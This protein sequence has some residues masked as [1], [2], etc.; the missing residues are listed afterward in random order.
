MPYY[1]KKIVSGD[2]VEIEQ[3]FSSG[4]RIP[5][6]EKR[7]ITPLTQTEYNERQSEKEFIRLLNCNFDPAR[8]D[9]FATLTFSEAVD[10]TRAVKAFRN[11]E[12]RVK[13]HCGKTKAEYK[14]LSMIEQQ[15]KW[16]I[17][18]VLS[19][20]TLEELRKLWGHGRVTVSPLDKSDNYKDLAGYLFEQEKPSRAD[21]NTDNTKQPR[22]KF[23]KRWSGTRNL[24][25]P[26]VTVA[27]IKR[28]SVMSKIP[29]APKG[30]ALLP[31][32]VISCDACGH[33]VRR[34]AYVKLPRKPQ[35]NAKPSG[36]QRKQNPKTPLVYPLTC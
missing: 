8:G 17:H 10:H 32:W 14:R 9:L 15:G 5:R 3:F 22:R 25:K 13:R 31:D 26:V 2:Y 7:G 18:M 6:G 21:P 1:E 29:T 33:L 24:K 16:H 20:L 19:G 35:S 12:L 27:Q 28:E 36:K 23:A 11:F 30:Y 4:K 34:Y